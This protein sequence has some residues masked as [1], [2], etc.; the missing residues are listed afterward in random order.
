[1]PQLQPYELAF[2]W[3]A[4][5]HSVVETGSR[6]VRLSTR[7]LQ[8]GVIKSSYADTMKGATEANNKGTISLNKVRDTLK[9][10]EK[11]LAIRKEGEP[12]QEGTLYKILIPEEMESCVSAMKYAEKK[13]REAAKPA[14]TA[15]IDYYNVKE[16]RL[17]IYER[18]SYKCRYCEKQLTRLTA[19]LDHVVAITQGGNN[20]YD[21]LVT[22]CLSCNSKKHMRPIGDFL[23]E[24]GK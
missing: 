3:Y 19:T 6:Y 11:I 8:N 18:D 17:K 24:Q 10:L 16:N 5:R 4:F 15:D 14:H 22:A 7:K 23:A 1:M 2:Y 9:N 20:T 13:R 21:N 12:N